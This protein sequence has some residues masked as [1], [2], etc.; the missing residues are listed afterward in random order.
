MDLISGEWHSQPF[1]PLKDGLLA[2]YPPLREDVTCDAVVIGAGITGALIAYHLAEAGIATVVLDRRDVGMG[3]T[4]GTTALLQYEIDVPLGELIQH[5]GENHAMRSY[6][7]CLQAINKLEKL[8]NQLPDSCS[9][10]R[11]KSVF[12]ASQRR[13]VAMLKQELEL[14]NQI[15]IQVDWLDQAQI[16]R[17]FGFTRPAALL[18]HDAAELNAFK[19]THQLLGRAQALGARVFDRTAM[20]RVEPHDGGVRVQTDRNHT[21]TARKIVYAAGYEAVPL[22]RHKVA[23]LISTYAFV[24]EPMSVAGLEAH[25]LIEH[26]L[27]ESAHPYFY[28]RTVQEAEDQVRVIMGGEDVPFRNPA[29]RDKLLVRKTQTLLKKFAALFPKLFLEVA[30]SWAGTFAETADGLAYIGETEEH[31]QAYFALGYGGNGITYSVLAAEIIRDA[32]LG[33]PNADADLFRFDRPHLKGN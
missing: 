12:L 3:S 32:I 25:G 22:L 14:R 27:W 23:D 17:R 1:W 21:V 20:S 15:G 9:F 10:Q 29:V 5:V 16:K 11:K 33:R 7:A 4:S 30:Y 8:A 13:D 24:S 28:L 18:S 26:M 19:F 6:L 31:P 2:A